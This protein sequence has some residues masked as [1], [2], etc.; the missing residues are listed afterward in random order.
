MISV[1]QLKIRQGE[2]VLNDVSFEVPTGQFAALMGKTGS[3]KTTILEAVCGLRPISGG[4]I[5]LSGRD[6]TQLR[7]SERGIGYVPQDGVLFETMTVA[8]HLSFALRI[9]NWEKKRIDERVSEM[10]ELLEI[11]HLLNRTPQ[12]LSGGEEQRVSLG[13]AL[14]FHPKILLL[15][16]PLSA[17]DDDTREHM[18][19]VIRRVRKHVG[20]TAM[21]ITHNRSEADALG[22]LHLTLRDGK[23]E[24]AKQ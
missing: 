19:D 24:I 21:H 16:E 12:G 20:F 4:T 18:Y 6:V 11:S 2:F 15:D 14:S 9:R 1:D 23:V 8:E 5:T 10:A 7:C 17:L 3:G 13:R 22:D